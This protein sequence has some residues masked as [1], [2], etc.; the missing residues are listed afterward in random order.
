MCCSPRR[1][2]YADKGK[3]TRKVLKK[4]VD[5]LLDK[6]REVDLDEVKDELLFKAETLQAE[7][8]AL[9]K[10]KAKDLALEQAQKIKEKAEE[11]Y[12]YAIEKSTPVVEKAA[13]EVRK[14]A[15]KVV[16]EIQEKLEEDGKQKNK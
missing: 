15:L 6:L 16:K 4:K 14:Q 13:D 10:E 9:D 8:A 7:L 5:E 11:L 12:K 1:R 2:A 3:N